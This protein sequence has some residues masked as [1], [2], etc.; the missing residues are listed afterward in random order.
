MA[1]YR[2]IQSKLA[3]EG[4]PIPTQSKSKDSGVSDWV[5]LHPPTGVP[6][7]DLEDLLADGMSRA[8]LF[9]YKGK[10]GNLQREVNSVELGHFT[11]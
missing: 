2:A 4:E 7:L 3:R 9:R 11:P 5:F 1:S 10:S 8:W 6:D